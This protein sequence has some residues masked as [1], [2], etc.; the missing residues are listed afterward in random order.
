MGRKRLA[1]WYGPANVRRAELI[2]KNIQAEWNG[3]PALTPEERAELDDLQERC[4][5]EVYRVYPA[6]D[7]LPKLEELE[8]LAR[9]LE[10]EKGGDV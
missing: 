7:K 6:P 9:R 1:K 8:E 2:R 5:N 4:L 10:S 3:G